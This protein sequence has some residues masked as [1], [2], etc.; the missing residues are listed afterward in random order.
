MYHECARAWD[1]YVKCLVFLVII[2]IDNDHGIRFNPLLIFNK[3][4]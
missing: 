3:S 1:V 4:D 2:G